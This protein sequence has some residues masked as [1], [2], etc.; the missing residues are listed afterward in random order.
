LETQKTLLYFLK[1]TALRLT[2]G[3]TVL[4]KDQPLFY[5][6]RMRSKLPFYSRE[7]IPALSSNIFSSMNRF[8]QLEFTLN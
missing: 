7:S 8:I 5:A 3:A 1:L 2:W 6:D 4:K